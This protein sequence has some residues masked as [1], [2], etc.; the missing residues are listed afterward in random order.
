M[1]SNDGL[2]DYPETIF[3]ADFQHVRTAALKTEEATDGEEAVIN[4]TDDYAFSFTDRKREK[5]VTWLD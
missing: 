4:W 2:E 3:N 1:A 5:T